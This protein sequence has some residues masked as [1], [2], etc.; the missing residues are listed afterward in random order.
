MVTASDVERASMTISELG[1]DEALRRLK[2]VEPVL[3]ESA[4]RLTLNATEHLRKTGML[5]DLDNNIRDKALVAV[6]S[7][8]EAVRVAGHRSWRQ[9]TPGAPLLDDIAADSGHVGLG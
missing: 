9:A 7:A 2:V 4:M 3:G 6:L 5:D 8:I 1:H